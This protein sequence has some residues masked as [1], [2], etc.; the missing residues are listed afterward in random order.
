MRVLTDDP[1]TVADLGHKAGC[2]L[3]GIGGVGKSSI[4]GRV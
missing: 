2:Q 1:R 3:L 4:A